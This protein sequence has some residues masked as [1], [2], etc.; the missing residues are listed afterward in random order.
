MTTIEDTTE[1]LPPSPRQWID[2]AEQMGSD[3]ETEPVH[4]LPRLRE[5]AQEIAYSKLVIFETDDVDDYRWAVFIPYKWPGIGHM[6][7]HTGAFKS[8]A[9][10]LVMAREALDLAALKGRVA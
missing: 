7:W 10:A 8:Y 2:P 6:G 9:E 4:A 5:R 1:G 3:D